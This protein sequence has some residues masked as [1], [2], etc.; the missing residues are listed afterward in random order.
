[1]EIVEKYY[2][3]LE[4]IYSI[5]IP[6]SKIHSEKK[7]IRPDYLNEYYLII[8]KKLKSLLEKTIHANESEIQELRFEIKKFYQREYFHN[9]HFFMSIL[10]KE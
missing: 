8:E 4:K 10:Y 9:V 1:M 3:Q 7:A 2:M 5:Y 6:I